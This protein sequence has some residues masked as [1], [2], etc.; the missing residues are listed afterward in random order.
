MKIPAL[1]FKASATSD[2]GIEIIDLETLYQRR[3]TM[4]TPYTSPHRVNF[5]VMLYIECGE[6]NHLIDFSPFPFAAGSFIFINKGQVHAF[7]FSHKLQGKAIV[8]T[9]DF[10]AKVQANM[11]VSL[12]SPLYL[13]KRYYPVFTPEVDTLRSCQAIMS[14]INK[15]LHR[16]NESGCLIM[17][18]F[19]ALLSLIERNRPH[20][21]TNHSNPNQVKLFNRFIELLE[22]DFAVS[23]EASYYAKQLN[24][25]YKTL[26]E[27]CKS[28][29]NQTAKQCIDA[30]TIIEAK[31][32]L[33]IEQKQV[34][35]VAFELGFEEPSNFVKY[36]RKHNFLSPL[37]FQKQ[38]NV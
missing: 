15:E 6:G 25:T 37:Q 5:Y 32:R 2:N 18:L 29:I 26:N 9:D 21:C 17:L 24:T 10:L 20:Y 30:Y 7:D 19:S 8:F 31:R 33:I 35:Q 3:Q 1:N 23:R 4:E 34:Q 28:I 22:K 13:S 11:N 12:F 38:H 36:F 16:D 14:E 27:S